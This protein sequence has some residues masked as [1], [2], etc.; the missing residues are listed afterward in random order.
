MNILNHGQTEAEASGEHRGLGHKKLSKPR[1]DQKSCPM[2][3]SKQAWFTGFPPGRLPTSGPESAGL[4]LSPAGAS[5]KA[6]RGLIQ[7]GSPR[8]S[9]GGSRKPPWLELPCYW[10]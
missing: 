5:C 1:K 3:E 10:T 2:G 9:V 8:D 4:G 7:N 6:G